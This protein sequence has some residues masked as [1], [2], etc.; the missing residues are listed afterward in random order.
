MAVRKC[1]TMEVISEESPQNKICYCKSM[2]YCRCL[3]CEWNRFVQRRERQSVWSRLHAS[4][5]CSGSLSPD[6]S[7][8]PCTLH[9]WWFFKS[10][11]PRGSKPIQYT[12][13]FYTNRCWTFK[14]EGIFKQSQWAV[15]WTEWNPSNCRDWGFLR[16]SVLHNPVVNKDQCPPGK[17]LIH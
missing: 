11:D 5:I 8:L 1:L 13:I 12:C 7:N 14:V 2:A 16:R 3:N 10:S 15:T 17:T 4:R 9:S 6:I